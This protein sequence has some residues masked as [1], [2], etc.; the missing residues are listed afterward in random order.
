MKVRV[1][2]LFAVVPV[3]GE[4]IVLSP[5][6]TVP[7]RLSGEGAIHI[8]VAVVC[9]PVSI[10]PGEAARTQLAPA[11]TFC[12]VELFVPLLA[13][14]PRVIVTTPG[15]SEPEPGPPLCC[16]LT[17]CDLICSELIR[18]DLTCPDLTCGS[19]SS[20]LNGFESPQADA[21]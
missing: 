12:E 21:G 11:F 15:G 5:Q 14:P 16:G 9:C 2:A 10:V 8:K 3:C 4:D 17:C 18:T 7:D 1:R 13:L 19:R 20:G 6:F